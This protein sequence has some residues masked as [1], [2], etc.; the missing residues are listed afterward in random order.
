MGRRGDTLPAAGRGRRGAHDGFAVFADAAGGG[1]SL[2]LRH[3]GSGA[4]ECRRY[5][6]PPMPP[7]PPSPGRGSRVLGLHLAAAGGAGG[8]SARGGRGVAARRPRRLHRRRRCRSRLAADRANWSYRC[9]RLA[10]VAREE[11]LQAW[12]AASQV[13]LLTAECRSR[14][15]QWPPALLRSGRTPRRRSPEAAAAAARYL[16]RR[17]RDGRRCW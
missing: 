11:V 16:H 8:A 13:L 17:L 10:R 9:G 6:A 3:H 14:G 1:G 12:P 7:S 5:A 2:R 4:Q 15:R